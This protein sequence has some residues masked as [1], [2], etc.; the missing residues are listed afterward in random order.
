MLNT[1]SIINNILAENTSYMA[2]RKLIRA[3]F[4]EVDKELSE[5]SY[6]YAEALYLLIHEL[7]SRPLC[8]HCSKELKYQDRTVGYG[9]YCSHLCYVK[10]GCSSDKRKNTCLKKYGTTNPLG[11]PNVRDKRKTTMIEKYGTE[12]PL[13]NASLND[14][15]KETYKKNDQSVILEKRKSTVRTKYGVDSIW[16]IPEIEERRKNT[17]IKKYGV[18]F[19]MQLPEIAGR[20]VST[21]VKNCGNRTSKNS[22]NESTLYIRKY[23][24]EKNYTIDQVAY[25][26]K[27]LGLFEWGMHFNNR[28]NMFDLVV[29]E[30][31]FRG[32]I[33]HIIE[34]LEYQGP[35][36]YTEKEAAEQGELPSVP[37]KNC[38]VTIKE[39]VDIDNAKRNFLKDRNIP[40][41]EVKPEKYWKN[42]I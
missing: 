26:D 29:F 42:R 22:S 6:N 28:W 7:G 17:N 13:Q 34:V 12:F 16:K 4:P 23:I 32:D 11:S 36:H 39:S 25:A 14:K 31:G 24:T 5:S 3:Q 1:I 40:L 41:I 8:K 18:E 10:D 35:F 2:Y 30:L 19:A 20:G 38:K 15:A 27:E 9:T 37:W 33:D 21:R